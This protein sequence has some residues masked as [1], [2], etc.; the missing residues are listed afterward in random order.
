DYQGSAQTDVDFDDT[1]SIY[2]GESITY[3]IKATLTPI[4]IGTL[5]GFTASV[6]DDSGSLVKSSSI[7]DT[8][9]AEKVLSVTDSDIS[10]SKTTS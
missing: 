6:T 3:Q 1:V 7:S 8:V 9:D 2:P 4:T 10:I 5:Q